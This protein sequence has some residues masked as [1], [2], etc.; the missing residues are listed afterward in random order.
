MANR[1]GRIADT[2]LRDGA[3]LYAVGAGIRLRQTEDWRLSPPAG[4]GM[5]MEER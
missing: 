4:K 1:A 3:V 5:P 2:I